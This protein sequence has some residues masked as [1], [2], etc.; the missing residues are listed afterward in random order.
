MNFWLY[1][2]S[3]SPI[4]PSHFQATKNPI[5]SFPCLLDYCPLSDF[6]SHSANDNHPFF[7]EVAGK[8]QN[9]DIDYFDHLA[10]EKK[11]G[12]LITC[13]LI[14]DKNSSLPITVDLSMFP[15]FQ[16]TNSEHLTKDQIKAALEQKRNLNRAPPKLVSKMEDV[17]ITDF[18]DNILF[19]MVM[20]SVKIQRITEITVFR[21]S[22]FMAPYI[23]HLQHARASASS[24]IEGKICK[25]LGNCLV[26]NKKEE[27]YSNT[28]KYLRD[29]Y[30]N[31]N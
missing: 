10:H 1:Q 4:S 29:T 27:N 20:M 17:E 18:V 31:N 26:G 14:Y 16:K 21:H 8:L 25:S 7:R 12:L 19:L 3:V 2:L 30:K 5:F 22:Q 28:N 24:S 13:D 6:R 23:L 9:L 11:L 15:R